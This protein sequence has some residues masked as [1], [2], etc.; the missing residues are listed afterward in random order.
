MHAKTHIVLWALV[1]VPM[2][3][4]MKEMESNALVCLH[5]VQGLDLVQETQESMCSPHL[6]S[7]LNTI[8]GCCENIPLTLCQSDHT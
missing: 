5:W 2:M 4:K 7:G 8:P 3:V 1:M 6:E